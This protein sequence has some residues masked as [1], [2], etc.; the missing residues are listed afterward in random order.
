MALRWLIPD[1]VIRRLRNVDGLSVQA[2]ETGTLL[3][4]SAKGGKRQ[5]FRV[6]CLS[7]LSKESAEK[8]SETP[9]TGPDHLLLAVPRLA[10]DTR[11]ILSGSG[12]SWIE[13]ETGVCHLAAPGILVETVLK[14]PGQSADS[15]AAR[16]KLIDRS[17]LIAEVILVSFLGEE[18]RLGTVA[19]QAHVSNALVSRIFS[20]LSSLKI[21]EQEGA[22]PYRSWRLRDPGAL[23]ELWST[24]E[25]RPVRT[26]SIYVWSRSPAELI[27]KLPRLHE[28]KVQW[29]VSG[30][31]A[32]NLY[33]PT[34]S[35]TPDPTIWFD[36]SHPAGE[37]A[38]L[39][40]GEIV[41]KGANLQVWQSP[42]NFP[43]YNLK[44]QITKGYQQSLAPGSGLLN[45]V[46]EPRAY[47]ESSGLPGRA[48]EVA[49][50]LREGILKKHG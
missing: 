47:V 6:R 46:S 30:L 17:G 5:R 8:Q 11:N 42:A 45:L 33:A 38:S 37:V 20:R 41:E 2:D 43:L 44:P 9:Q 26:T 23:L 18:L 29:A 31:C 16:A 36:A 48:L 24:E 13:S 39:L 15:D 22:G 3:F 4:L 35:T 19:R 50:N 49:Q 28:L 1:W 12:F 14:D 21:L 32:A 40:G 25:R 34:L 27:G 7:V 10:P